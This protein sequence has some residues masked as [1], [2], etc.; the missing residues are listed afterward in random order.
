MKAA[1]F[2]GGDDIRVRD[3]PTPVPGPGQALVRVLA[4]G[5]CGSDLHGY[6]DRESKLAQ[7]SLKG[8]ELAGEIAA[9]GPGVEGLAV[10]QRVGVEP[11]HLVS[12]GRCRWC[13][14]GDTQLCPEL[15][16][17]DG[18]RVHSTGFAEYSLEAAA[19]CYP[20][21]DDL[22]IE[23][24]AILDVYAVAVHAVHR[25]PVRPTDTVAVLGTGAIGLATAQ[26][27]R[28]AGAGRV[29][30]IG[31]REEPLALAR[32]LGCDRT[33]NVARDGQQDTGEAV[34]AITAG[35]GADVVYEA[36]GGRADTLAQAIRAAARGGRVGVIG[37]FGDPQTVDARLCMR[38]ELSLVWVWSY[39]LWDGV[40]EYRIALDGLAS[41][42]IDAAPLI[43]HR[44]PLAR[45]GTAF[46]AADDKRASGAIKVLVLPSD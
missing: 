35:H 27:A 37:A 2:Y 23:E 3:V 6:R 29:I 45:I 12:C 5:V 34:R 43:T 31:R 39:G 4:A 40:P 17:L 19:N 13:R 9:L 24:A 16:L 21:P 20:L 32:Q 11:G 18:K 26:V 15:G 14:R 10:G 8:H 38:H 22:S 7:P 33:V 46:A 42:R 41:G 44:F 30:V 1:L 25:V 36:V 28:A